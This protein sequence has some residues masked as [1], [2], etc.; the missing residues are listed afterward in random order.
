MYSNIIACFNK[1]WNIMYTMYSKHN[2]NL[3]L[4]IGM[5]M[6]INTVYNAGQMPIL[7]GVILIKISH[8]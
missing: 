2:H 1:I 4:T 5:F 7:Y 6:Y 3:F 8:N